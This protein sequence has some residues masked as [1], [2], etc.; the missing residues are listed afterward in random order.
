MGYFRSGCSMSTGA[1]TET[2]Y[3]SK[4]LVSD[5]GAALLF[6]ATKRTLRFFV[7]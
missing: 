7:Q 2:L 3:Y 1:P 4:W 6:I 5:V